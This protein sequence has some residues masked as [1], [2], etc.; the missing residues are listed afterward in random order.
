MKALIKFVSVITLTAALFT[1]IPFSVS[2]DGYDHTIVK[3][4]A[5]FD[6]QTSASGIYIYPNDSKESR[7]IKADKYNFK[8]CRLLIF[9][10]DGLLIEAGNDIYP[11]TP[12]VTGSPQLSVTVPAGGFLVAFYPSAS[13]ELN[14]CYTTAMEGAM[15]YN[16]TMAVTYEVH[17]KI[18]RATNKLTVEYNDP[19]PASKDAVKYLFV[20]NSSTYFNGIPIKY[21]ALCKAEGIEIVADYCTFG[22]ANLGE[23]A[24]ETHERGRALRNKLKNT[25]Y[26]YVVVQNMNG[27]TYE[28]SKAALD[29][30]TPLI[31]ENGAE[32]LLYMRYSCS[33][34]ASL[35]T[36]QAHTHNINYT[37]LGT[38]FNAKV[39]PAADAFIICTDKYPDINL[40]ADDNGHHS[41]EGSYLI[42]CTLFYTFTGKSPVGNSY[43][44][45]LDPD[46][47]KKLQEC[48]VIACEYGYDYEN[49]GDGYPTLPKEESIPEETA[50]VSTETQESQSSEGESNTIWIV[51]G[52]VI[53]I[54]V[55][56]AAIL[57]I[58]RKS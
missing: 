56:A 7:V 26:D 18:D 57:I 20:G 58:K 16:A 17:A 55:I 49:T 54:A 32:L 10:A 41:A 22:S 42:A 36:E 11:N 35:R 12:T 34:D 50:Q 33:K 9:D 1:S 15:L 47:V 27:S 39:S 28:E 13:S 25:K 43:A 44:A 53:A 37:K 8:S 40:Y 14:A 46:T 5:G 29:I 19:S 2:A 30:I 24:D 4:I 45:N 38:D 52:I 48:A 6:T 23:F 31:K 21:K 3:D 51:L